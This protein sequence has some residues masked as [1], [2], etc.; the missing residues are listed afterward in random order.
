MRAENTPRGKER[1]ASPDNFRIKEKSIDPRKLMRG[2]FAFNALDPTNL[3]RMSGENFDTEE[4]E[5]GKAQTVRVIDTDP[6]NP[7]GYLDKP[8]DG[9]HR[10][11]GAAEYMEKVNP[12]YDFKVNDITD[13]RIRTKYPGQKH[14]T[15]LQF[16]E[17][18]TLPTTAH[19]NIAPHRMALHFITEWNNIVGE[20]AGTSSGLAAITLL[21]MDSFRDQPK[22]VIE[23]YFA[24]NNNSLL[25]ETPEGRCAIQQGLLGISNQIS[26]TNTGYDEIALK[27]FQSIAAL[28]NS[29]EDEMVRQKQIIGLFSLPEVTRKLTAGNPDEDTLS[30]R[31]SNLYHLITKAIV[32]TST[33]VKQ[34]V[35]LREALMSSYLTYN[36]LITVLQ[37][38]S[39]TYS[40]EGEKDKRILSNRYEDVVHAV[41]QRRGIRIYKK[42]SNGQIPSETEKDLIGLLCRERE[43]TDGKLSHVVKAVKSAAVVVQRAENAM[44]MLMPK[45][46]PGTK[47]IQLL[48]DFDNQL[49]RLSR[50]RTPTN[51]NAVASECNRLLHR[52]ETLSS[53]QPKAELSAK[54]AIIYDHTQQKDE[55]PPQE[56]RTTGTIDAFVDFLQ[57]GGFS[58]RDKKRLRQVKEKIDEILAGDTD[59]NVIQ[60]DK[61]IGTRDWLKRNLQFR[62]DGTLSKNNRQIFTV[63]I[64]RIAQTELTDERTKEAW[65]DIWIGIR[66]RE[67]NTGLDAIDNTL[68]NRLTSLANRLNWDKSTPEFRFL[69]ANHYA[70]SA[71]M[72]LNNLQNSVDEPTSQTEKEQLAI[73][74]A[75]NITI[76][77]ALQRFRTR[78]FTVKTNAYLDLLAYTLYTSSESEPNKEAVRYL[79][80]RNSNAELIRATL[81]RLQEYSGYT[82]IDDLFRA[83]FLEKPQD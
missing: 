50:L 24:A 56:M 58:P 39:D 26:E 72:Y 18:A 38:P 71:K 37:P 9:Y 47:E 27:T 35:A 44:Q 63:L 10:I 1:P 8:V 62:T 51:L 52:F 45:A 4:Y 6:T 79:A 78:N 57:E 42:E 80:M 32:D 34:N 33:D 41:N 43:M 48:N 60:I 70:L 81:E 29:E 30:N 21:G 82:S 20:A 66:D 5:V 3:S 7:E 65:E 68:T 77:R 14:L 73:F 59:W 17:E 11:A 28:S 55:K 13:R 40:P 49:E 54:A 67:G 23:K 19:V 64:D 25:G 46:Q 53:P 15:A 2:N 74:K 61:T 31:H 36:D 22:R 12:E 16:M 69:C 76:D 75:V 83:T